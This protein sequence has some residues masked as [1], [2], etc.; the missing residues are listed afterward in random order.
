MKLLL[1]IAFVC[2]L[3]ACSEQSKK[4]KISKAE[5]QEQT[6]LMLNICT[7]FSMEQDAEKLYKVALS[8]QQARVIT[9]V[10]VANECSIYGRFIS[11]A[12]DIAKDG[13]LSSSDHTLLRERLLE[14]KKAIQSGREKLNSFK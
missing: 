13:E 4:P 7:K 12:I 1:V 5:Y 11:T 8:V 6:Q 14:L 3:S 2:S 9:C 10:D